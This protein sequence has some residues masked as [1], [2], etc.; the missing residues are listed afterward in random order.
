VIFVILSEAKNL[1]ISTELTIEILRLPPQN[2]ITTQPLKVEDPNEFPPL[3]GEGQGG[4]GV[5]GLSV[6]VEAES[7][8]RCLHN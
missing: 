8:S 5:D 7:I 3:Q 1:I 4:G 6:G 2:D